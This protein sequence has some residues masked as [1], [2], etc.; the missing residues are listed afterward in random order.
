MII[1]GGGISSFITIECRGDMTL[2]ISRRHLGNG[3]PFAVAEQLPAVR[4]ACAA[5]FADDERM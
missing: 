3:M 4:P 1:L 2:T 5:V